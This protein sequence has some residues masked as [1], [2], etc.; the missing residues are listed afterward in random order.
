MAQVC[1]RCCLK[2]LARALL[3]VTAA[4]AM[5]MQVNT[6]GHHVHAV[7]IDGLVHA[8]HLAAALAH[9]LDAAVLDDNRAAV[10]P[11]LGCEHMAVINLSQ[12]CQS[13]LSLL[14]VQIY[15]VFC[16]VVC[17]DYIFFTFLTII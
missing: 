3:E 9:L 12:H 4:T 11:S 14:E 16:L 10:D 15:I 2:G 8:F 1:L 5:A 7:G 6:T 13:F 17:G